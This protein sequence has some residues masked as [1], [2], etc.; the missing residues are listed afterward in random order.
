M[1]EVTPLET[2]IRRR[3]AA[4]G[5]MPVSEYMALCLT[6]STHGYYTTRDPLGGAGDFVT[7]P[8]I[9]QMF[10][11]IIGLWLADA[12]SACGR[13]APAR[14]VELGPGRGTLMADL[15]RATARL[16]GFHQSMSIH[17]VERSPRLR[18]L[19]SERLAGVEVTW[20]DRIEEV[21]EGPLFLVAN[22]LFDALPVHQL[23]R[24][25]QGWVDRRVGLAA[26]GGL[27]FVLAGRP[28]ALAR[29][30][31]DAA[32]GTVAELSPA[33]AHLAR[34]IAARIAA[35][36]GVAL[37]IDYGAFS[38]G[39]TGDTLQAVRGQARADPLAAPG[40]ADLSTQVDFRALAEAASA[41]G[42]AVFGPVPQGTFLRAFGIEARALQLLKW[43]RPDQRRNLRAGL[44]RLTD[45]AAMGEMFKVLVLARPDGSPPP[46]FSAP[47]VTPAHAE[48]CSR[49]RTSA[50]STASGTVS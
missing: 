34:Q 39:P 40:D 9:S 48:P 42:A 17:L 26:D 20:H 32:P 8:E 24:T 37:L 16:E 18:E 12:W 1:A 49:P 30:L 27:A 7:A 4:A 25:G 44:F 19:Q 43:A 11:E 10:G 35:A 46:G 6:D 45:A 47:T 41:G 15:L 5:P 29:S 36:G 2:E 33:R 14:L 21:P 38:Q 3:I 22:E 50:T 13:P 23:V 28:S 31:P